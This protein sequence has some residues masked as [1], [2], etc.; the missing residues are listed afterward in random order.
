MTKA[1][2][3]LAIAQALWASGHSGKEAKK[4]ATELIE[5]PLKKK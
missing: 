5:K 2:A 3:I 4:I 1:E